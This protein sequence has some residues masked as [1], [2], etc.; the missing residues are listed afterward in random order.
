LE[1][2][3]MHHPLHTHFSGCGCGIGDDADF[4]QDFSNLDIVS[5]SATPKD[6]ISN[7]GDYRQYHINAV[8]FANRSGVG[9][10]LAK[11]LRHHRMKQFHGYDDGMGFSLSDITGMISSTVSTATAQAKAQA[12]AAIDKAKADA[13]AAVAKAQATA[14]ANLKAQA[15][16]AGQKVIAQAQQSVQN[17]TSNLLNQAVNK[18]TGM[19]TSLVNQAAGSSAVQ[20]SLSS[21][22]D[23]TKAKI[24][25]FV[26]TA[27]KTGKIG[28]YAT[29]GAVALYIAWKIY[30]S[31]KMRLV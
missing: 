25:G 10:P 2:I 13:A 28:M 4:G 31:R 18:A 7:F 29:G 15:T 27:K 14:M 8:K 16:A 5:D 11:A 6:M 19:T 23:N 3:K 26:D 30:K 20:N 24:Q 21:V 9:S 22:I 12:Q 17:A 1:K